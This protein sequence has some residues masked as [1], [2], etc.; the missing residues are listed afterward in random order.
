MN[1]FRENILM[2][3][4]APFPPDIRLE[5]EIRSLT[6]AGY[7]VSLLCNQYEENFSP[8]FP[9][10]NII[11]VKALFTNKKLNKIINIPFFLNPRFIYYLFKTYFIVKPNFIHAHDLPMAPL[12]L[13]LGKLYKKPVIFDMHENYP[14]ALKAFDKKGFFNFLFKNYRLAS[15]LEKKILKHV[16]KVLVV[17]EENKIRL[18]NEGLDEN[19]VEVVSNTVDFN[20]FNYKYEAAGEDFKVNDKFVVAYSG[21]VSPDRGL[22]TPVRALKYFKAKLP[23]F[24]MMIIGD[25]PSIPILKSIA[26][27]DGTE[28]FVKFIKWP[29]HQNLIKY[30]NFADVLMIPQ[31]AN[32]F[33][34]TTIPH[35]L[36]EYMLIGKPVIVSNALPLKRIVNETTSG[37]VFQSNNEKDFFEKI[38]IIKNSTIPYGKNGRTAVFNK[39]NWDNDS[40]KLLGVY[41]E[42]AERNYA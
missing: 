1:S 21:G 11:R 24:M 4:Q 25:G 3:L 27:A 42:L 32:D 35:K 5:K 10:C 31:P 17:I 2:L 26:Q 38:L 14:Q 19:K 7:N 40:Q 18:V 39:Y 22:E 30:L 29:G 33:I 34:N 28:G 9:F 41:N 15:L 16:D 13:M 8:D 23:N 12:G 20:T 37:E 36:F 6:N